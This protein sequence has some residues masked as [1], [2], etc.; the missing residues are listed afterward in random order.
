[1]KKKL[2]YVIYGPEFDGTDYSHDHPLELTNKEFKQAATD[3]GHVYTSK[4]LCAEWNTDSLPV[5]DSYI[6]YL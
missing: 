3:Q 6:K 2:F 5:I 4:E 1:M